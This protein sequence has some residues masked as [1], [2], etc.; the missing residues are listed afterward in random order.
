MLRILSVA[1]LIAVG[2]TAVAA[3]NLDVIKARKETLK[4]FGAAAKE[5]GAMIKGEAK[6]DMAKVQAALKTFQAGAAKLPDL[7]PDDSKTGGETEALPIIWEKKAD[8]VDRYKKLAAESKAAE[9]KISDEI[10]FQE[11]WPKLLGDNCGACHKIYR[12]PQ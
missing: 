4:G 1:A 8:L 12:K 9:A 3:Q 2:A 11:T 5:P 6:F 7:F 10:G